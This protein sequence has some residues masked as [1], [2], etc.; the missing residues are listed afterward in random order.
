MGRIILRPVGA[1]RGSRRPPSG[2]PGRFTLGVFGNSAQRRSYFGGRCPD[3]SANW[4]IAFRHS[5]PSMTRTFTG[6]NLRERASTRLR[7][8]WNGRPAR[9]CR[10][11]AGITSGRVARPGRDPATVPLAPREDVSGEPPE[12]TG[13]R[14]VPPRACSAALG[15]L[16]AQYLILP[17]SNSAPP[18][19]G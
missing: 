10:R 11:P 3:Q 12:T 8:G 5:S 13:Q 17:R 16:K 15:V 6:V 2:N 9:R 14:P 1:C 7:P 18:T 4:P 19:C